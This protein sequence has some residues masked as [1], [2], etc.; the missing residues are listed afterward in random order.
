MLGS[1]N[2][3]A[4]FRL[5]MRPCTENGQIKIAEFWQLNQKNTEIG[6]I[7]R[8]MSEKNVIILANDRIEN[9]RIRRGKFEKMSNFIKYYIT[10]LGDI[11]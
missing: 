11:G 3:W 10:L 7:R 9:L 4:G 8:K 5:E 1:W 2:V 6:R